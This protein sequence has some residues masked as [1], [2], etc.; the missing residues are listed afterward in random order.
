MLRYQ[1]RCVFLADYNGKLSYNFSII[2]NKINQFFNLKPIT[3]I[4]NSKLISYSSQIHPNL[5]YNL[6]NNSGKIPLRKL[7]T[8]LLTKYESDSLISKEK[9]G[10]SVNTINL[11]N[12]IGRELCHSYLDNARIVE[13]GWI[14]KEWISSHITKSNLDVQY[15]N[16]F[17]GLLAVE[18][19]YRLFVTKELNSTT[20]LS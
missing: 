3:P 4:L 20:K 11:W 6:L 18:I 17:L 9:L 7:L 15:I 14:N 16:K 13:D 19:W 2:G 10:F 5:K 1:S 8:K 12:S